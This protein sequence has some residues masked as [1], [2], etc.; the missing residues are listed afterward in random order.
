M[1]LTLTKPNSPPTST[2]GMFTST[3]TSTAL[4]YTSSSTST[5]IQGTS[6]AVVRALKEMSQQRIEMERSIQ[7][8]TRY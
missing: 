1:S 2:Q 6:T 7:E 5:S 3:S 8:L 4:P